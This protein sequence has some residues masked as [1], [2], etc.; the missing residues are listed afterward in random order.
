MKYIFIKWGDL[1]YSS[2]FSDV[3]WKWNMISLGD[4]I[5][6]I[7]LL[8]KLYQNVAFFSGITATKIE[9]WV[10]QISQIFYWKH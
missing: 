1:K 6:K 8:Q 10:E 9:H 4:V 5:G 3:I 7:S 2:R